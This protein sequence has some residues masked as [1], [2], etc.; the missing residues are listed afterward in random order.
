MSIDKNNRQQCN[1]EADDPLLVEGENSAEEVDVVIGAVKSNQSNNKA[2]DELEPTP[3]VEA[4]KP[5]AA[6]LGF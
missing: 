5:A 1:Y 4:K 2:A 3:T 6:L